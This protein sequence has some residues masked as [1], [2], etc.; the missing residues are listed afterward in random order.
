MKRRLLVSKAAEA[1]LLEIWSY[2]AE[3]FGVSQADRYL[4]R[5]AS[6]LRACATSPNRG[7]RRDDL[8]PGYRSVL[9]RRHVAFYT[10]NTDTV[11]VQRVLHG[12]MDPD[13][14]LDDE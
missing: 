9:I 4:E 1:D 7:R 5:L 11:L 14:N 13:R 6:G 12:S 3:S 2:T 8:R 10:F